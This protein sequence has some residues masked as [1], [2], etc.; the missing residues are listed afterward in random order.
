MS[1]YNAATEPHTVPIATY[2]FSDGWAG[3]FAG[4]G[5][6]GGVAGLYVNRVDAMAGR[7]WRL[8]AASNVTMTCVA[9]VLLRAATAPAGWRIT[10]PVSDGEYR[11]TKRD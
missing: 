7:R 10:V 2:V 9:L 5:L 6:A 3:F 4:A 11:L 1:R 8:G